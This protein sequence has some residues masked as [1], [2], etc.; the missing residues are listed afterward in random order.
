MCDSILFISV[1][2]WP[3]LQKQAKQTEE[4]ING[5]FQKLYQFLRAEEAA[6]IDG[7]RK[8][9]ADK[10]QAMQLRRVDLI[11][12]TSSLSKTVEAAET[13]LMAENLSFMIVI[14]CFNIQNLCFYPLL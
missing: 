3:S 1:S 6:R 5:E 4:N 10:S 7:L 12:E 11:A 13:D 14:I 8:E 9:A 2:I